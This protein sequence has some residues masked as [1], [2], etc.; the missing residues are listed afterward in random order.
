MERSR[1]LSATGSARRQCGKSRRL[2]AQPTAHDVAYATA[3]AGGGTAVRFDR[4]RMIVRF[5]L[6]GDTE[7]VV[8]YKYSLEGFRRLVRG[9]G[10]DVEK[11][12]VDADSMFSVLYLTNT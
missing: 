1:A 6:E 11:Q 8:Q 12:W 7:F 10:L 3:H 9:A 2:G 5:R 4:R